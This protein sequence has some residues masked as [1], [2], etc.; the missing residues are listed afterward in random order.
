METFIITLVGADGVGKRSLAC[1]QLALHC[2]QQVVV[3]NRAGFLGIEIIRDF[4]VGTS[5][6]PLYTNN[7][8]YGREDLSI[9][10]GQGFV[11]IYSISSRATFEH[12]DELRSRIVRAKGAIPPM[13]VIGNKCD[14]NYDRDLAARFGCPFIETSA[15]TAQNVD[16]VFTD[17]VRELRKPVAS[18][19]QTPA[20]HRKKRGCIIG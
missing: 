11:L 19:P 3:D 8:E 18:H 1:Q 14:R 12:L 9:Q 20:D 10:R 17:L 4:T 15:K 2:L 5:Y 16:R 6:P 7:A 13:T